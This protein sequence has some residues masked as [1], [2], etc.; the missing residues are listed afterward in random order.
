MMNNYSKTLI[1]TLFKHITYLK[2][3]NFIALFK[4]LIEK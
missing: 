4:I 3:V 2:S 1:Q